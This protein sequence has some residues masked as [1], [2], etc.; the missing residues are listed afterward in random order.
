MEGSPPVGERTGP[1][2]LR[3][4]RQYLRA[5]AYRDDGL[6]RDRLSLYDYQQPRI[7][8]VGETVARLGNLDGMRVLDVGCGNGQ[9]HARLRAAGASVLGA[10]LS[11]GMLAA[12]RSAGAAGLF[13]SDAEALAVVDRGFDAALAMHM[14]YHVPRPAGAV[15]ELAR[16]LRP[17][18]KL[19]AAVGGPRHLAEA[20]AI[21]TP[22]LARAG[23]DGA[24][25][26]VG[27]V[28]ATLSAAALG[29]LLQDCFDD[30]QLH[31]LASKVVLDEPGPVV[32]HAASTT[33]WRVGR[34]REITMADEFAS[35]VRKVIDRDGAFTLTT[36]VALFTAVRSRGP[37]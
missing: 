16:A 1:D 21:W 34:Q 3:R 5:V 12:A 13:A 24:V 29:A 23:V 15:A 6:F 19:V 10:D 7:D 11:T 4:D 8:L 27:L 18:G 17:G 26:E 2:S 33:A 32:R 35:E 20:S 28:N 9:Y 36:E 37:V 30:V 31:L 14:L 25:R 22:L